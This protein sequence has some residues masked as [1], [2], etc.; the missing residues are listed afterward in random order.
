MLMEN[1]YR[2]ENVRDACDRSYFYVFCF[3]FQCRSAIKKSWY[4][5]KDFQFILNEDA[6][7]IDKQTLAFNR[8]QIRIDNAIFLRHWDRSRCSGQIASFKFDTL[9][10]VSQAYKKRFSH[11][12]SKAMKLF[13]F[14]NNQVQLFACSRRMPI[15]HILYRF[16]R[17]C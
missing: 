6:F 17:K 8:T 3:H 14:D 10:T 1:V 16:L 15:I 2:F 9:P 12:K 5:T 4:I 11:L 7:I 13:S